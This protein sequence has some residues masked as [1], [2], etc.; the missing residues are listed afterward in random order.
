MVLS[1]IA[2]GSAVNGNDTTIINGKVQL[3]EHP[4]EENEQDSNQ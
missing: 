1:L 4:Q 2:I 3:T